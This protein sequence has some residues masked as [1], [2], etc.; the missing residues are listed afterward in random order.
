MRSG[1][2]AAIAMLACSLG[3]DELFEQGY[4][5]LDDDGLVRPGRSTDSAALQSVVDALVD[6]MCP[7]LSTTTAA[8][9]ARRKR[10]VQA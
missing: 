9:F 8:D 2:S 7:A 5:V 1:I 4:L 6:G 3:C 10:L